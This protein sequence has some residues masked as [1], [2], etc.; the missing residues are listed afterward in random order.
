MKVGAAAATSLQ[1][2]TQC[3]DVLHLSSARNAKACFATANG[4]M[5]PLSSGHRTIATTAGMDK[6]LELLLLLLQGLKEASWSH[7][8]CQADVPTVT[9]VN[10]DRAM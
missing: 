2:R 3:S 4:H 1:H 7:I 10:I 9:V 5:R 6:T 8:R